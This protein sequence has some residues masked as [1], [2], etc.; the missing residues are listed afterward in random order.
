MAILW[1]N[2]Q[3]KKKHKQ[4]QLT[5]CITNI[6]IYPVINIHYTISESWIFHHAD[7]KFIMEQMYYFIT[8]F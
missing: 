5:Y 2:K 1:K 6:L 7:H 3:T 8:Y 4:Y